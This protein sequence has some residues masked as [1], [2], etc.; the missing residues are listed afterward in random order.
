MIKLR[1]FRGLLEQD[2]CRPPPQPRVQPAE[3][4]PRPPSIGLIP[5]RLS[6]TPTT[7]RYLILPKGADQPQP[8]DWG[9]QQAQP[10]VQ[11]DH[12][13]SRP[14]SGQAR[15]PAQVQAQ[16]SRRCEAC[17][18]WKRVTAAET[19]RQHASSSLARQLASGLKRGNVREARQKECR[20]DS[21]AP[22]GVQR[23]PK[24]AFDRGS[25]R[26]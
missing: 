15:H 13:S 21:A 14:Q 23:E 1:I 5:A 19:D 26:S 24:R 9:P 2:D 16:Q 22:R 7:L 6:T 11:L 20:A 18:R 10:P 4:S 3:F 12:H 25:R 17:K 8:L